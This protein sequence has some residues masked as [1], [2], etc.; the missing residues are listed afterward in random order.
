MG[1]EQVDKELEDAER[2][3]TQIIEDVCNDICDHYCKYPEM[4]GIEDLYQDMLYEEHC[5]GCALNRLR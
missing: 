3:V 4:Y 1:A 5:N 2:S